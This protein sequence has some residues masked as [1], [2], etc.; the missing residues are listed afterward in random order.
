MKQ[1]FEAVEYGDKI[2]SH[3]TERTEEDEEDMEVED[4]RDLIRNSN[5]VIGFNAA[6]PAPNGGG[7]SEG[8]NV[9]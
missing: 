6:E 8:N 9:P 5:T 3:S 4:A 2:V 7:S 1:F